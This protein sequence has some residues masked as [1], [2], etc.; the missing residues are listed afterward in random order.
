MAVGLNVTQ[1]SSL[2]VQHE[3]QALNIRSSP[4]TI[5]LGTLSTIMPLAAASSTHIHISLHLLSQG[6][7]LGLQRKRTQP[8]AGRYISVQRAH[9]AMASCRLAAT[10]TQELALPAPPDGA[11]AEGHR[12]QAVSPGQPVPQGA[13]GEA[14]GGLCGGEDCPEPLAVSKS[15][16]L[17]GSLSAQ[18]QSQRNHLSK[19]KWLCQ[20]W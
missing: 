3:S 7:C 14:G 17:R 11:A 19:W 2:L 18:G 20:Q 10:S 13:R 9:D 6:P 8:Q 15:T 4:L 16:Q 5:V 1:L 12:C